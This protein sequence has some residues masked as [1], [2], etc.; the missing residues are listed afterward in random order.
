MLIVLL[1]NSISTTKIK[2][3]KKKERV[4]LD[5]YGT[6]ICS[7]NCTTPTNPGKT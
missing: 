2:E 1:L 5:V 4:V 6:V 3:K 7:H